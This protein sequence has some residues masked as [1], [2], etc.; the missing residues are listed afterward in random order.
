MNPET[1]VRALRVAYPSGLLTELRSLLAA[2]NADL[3]QPM[4]VIYNPIFDNT[5]GLEHIA[6]D[7][8]LIL[9]DTLFDLK[10]SVR[11]FSGEQLWQILGYAALEYLHRAHAHE[12]PRFTRVGLYNPR[13]RALWSKPADELAAALGARSLAHFATWL[14]STPAAHGG[15]PNATRVVDRTN[16]ATRPALIAAALKVTAARTKAPRP[17]RISARNRPSRAPPRSPTSGARRN[18]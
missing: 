13:T 6:A 2:T 12:A 16:A 8:D 17:T 5:P 3:P 18:P 7:G 15:L 11:A 1:L 9:D 10:T 4:R 14:L